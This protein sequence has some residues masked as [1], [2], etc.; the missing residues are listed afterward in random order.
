MAGVGERT[1]TSGLNFPPAPQGAP[2]RPVASPGSSRSTSGTGSSSPLESYSPS[3]PSARVVS[4]GSSASSSTSKYSSAAAPGPPFHGARDARTRA[5]ADAT[6]SN[7]ERGGEDRGIAAA[8]DEYTPRDRQRR[9]RLHRAPKERVGALD[10]NAHS[11]GNLGLP[12]HTV[13]WRDRNRLSSN[14]DRHLE[15]AL[16]FALLK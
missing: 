2:N 14:L 16:T 11:L 15:F 4:A 8:I 7:S 9:V 5:A 1:R 6:L 3:S 10:G 13:T 12:D